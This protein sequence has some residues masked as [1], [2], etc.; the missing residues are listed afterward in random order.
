MKLLGI[1]GN[2]RIFFFIIMS[3]CLIF[4]SCNDQRRETPSVEVANPSDDLPPADVLEEEMLEFDNTINEMLQRYPDAQFSYP[5]Q[6]QMYGIDRS[7][8]PV[9]DLE[10]EKRLTPHLETTTPGEAEDLDEED[11][12]SRVVVKGISVEEDRKVIEVNLEK[13]LVNR[14]KL[15][16]RM[17]DR[18]VYY[19][20]DTN[21][22]PDVGFDQFRQEIA[23]NMQIPHE[24]IEDGIQGEVVF[25]FVVDKNGNVSEAK[26]V[27]E[28]FN[29]VP[30]GDY[31]E[32]MYKKVLSAIV[33]TS[34]SWQ[35]GTYQGAPVATRYYLPVSFNAPEGVISARQLEY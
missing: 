28:E 13:I 11:P 6:G 16:G 4:I 18:H 7:E 2:N 1:S 15:R 35:P 33:A 27:R 20:V 21:P 30:N 34:G 12:P 29:V 9:R 14:E 17:D 5:P 31:L 8:S 26:V 19:I 3:L 25:Q 24:A 23:R 32:N 10:P 22:V